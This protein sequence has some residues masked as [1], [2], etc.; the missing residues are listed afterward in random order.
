MFI[1][2]S[3]LHYSKHRVTGSTFF[4]PARPI[5]LL[6]SHPSLWLT[7]GFSSHFHLRVSISHPFY[8]WHKSL[9]S[10]SSCC[11]HSNNAR[12]SPC[13]C[14]SLTTVTS[15]HIDP[16]ITLRYLFT[17]TLNSC[18]LINRKQ[19][20]TLYKTTSG[21]VSQYKCFPTIFPWKNHK[22]NSSYAEEPIPMRTKKQR[23]NWWLTVV[24]LVLIFA[25]QKFQ[26]SFQG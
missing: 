17:K 24:T 19:V 22:N 18:S 20:C 1:S 4:F 13:L 6:F 23:G 5:F 7:S 11:N 2:Y 21:F 9:P 10:R 16:Y 12:W 14:S 26:K 3:S 25:G 8:A 15:S